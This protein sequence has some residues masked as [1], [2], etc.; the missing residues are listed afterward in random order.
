MEERM[1]VPSLFSSSN[2]TLSVFVNS[3]SAI[4]RLSLPVVKNQAA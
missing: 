3:L 1:R 4:A 2:P